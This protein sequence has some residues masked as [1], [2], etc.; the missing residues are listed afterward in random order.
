VNAG[1]PVA[2]CPLRVEVKAPGTCSDDEIEEFRALVAS[3]GE[4]AVAGLEG[5]VRSA[6]L[7]SFLRHGPKLIGVAGLKRPSPNHRAEVQMGAGIQMNDADAPLELGWVHVHPD[8]RGG[9]S[10]RLCAPLIEGAG[11][12][13]VFATSRANNAAMHA[14]LAKLRFE[15][16]GGEWPS[17]LN[18]EELWLFV[19][20]PTAR[21]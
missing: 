8:H 10:M 5:R 1:P 19:R 7:L 18:P 9:K 20:P 6:A 3:A 12:S 2:D 17:G 11:G 16:R 21:T 13:G 4:V 14:T 15:R